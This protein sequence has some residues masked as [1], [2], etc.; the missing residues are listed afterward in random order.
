[1]KYKKIFLVLLI[2]PNI[3]IAAS[4]VKINNTDEFIGYIDS[5]SIEWTGSTVTYWLLIDF[6]KNQVTNT[7]SKKYKSTKTKEVIDCT[8][9][10]LAYEYGAMYSKEMGAGE[11]I[12]STKLSRIFEPIIPE[13]VARVRFDFLCK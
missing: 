6:K 10:E 9:K 5:E 13:S 11:M 4:W 2:L 3:A 8:K 12:N 1:M 7:S